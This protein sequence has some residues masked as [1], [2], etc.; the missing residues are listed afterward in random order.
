M[1]ISFI[2]QLSEAECFSKIWRFILISGYTVGRNLKAFLKCSNMGQ[3]TV[4]MGK[5]TLI[6][7]GKDGLQKY[8]KLCI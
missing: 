5:I 1:S 7:M 2:S 8:K 4:H 6:R 3:I